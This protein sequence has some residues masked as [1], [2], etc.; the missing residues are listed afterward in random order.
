MGNLE[1]CLNH[2]GIVFR[3]LEQF[4][5]IFKV[6]VFRRP[7]GLKNGYPRSRSERYFEHR[8]RVCLLIFGFT[9]QP[10]FDQVLDTFGCLFGC[11]LGA[12]SGLLR[13]SWEA[14]GSKNIKKTNCLLRFVAM[15]L[16]GSLKLLMVS[17]AHLA[18]TLADLVPI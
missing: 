12:L 8:N 10:L 6:S 4:F 1:P 3:H 16:F 11:L 7:H 18:T 14:S 15:Q 13:F 5:D 9:F 17:W 2:F